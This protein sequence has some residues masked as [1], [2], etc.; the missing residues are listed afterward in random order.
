MNTLKI[1]TRGMQTSF[2]PGAMIEGTVSWEL[3]RRPVSM[4]LRLF[5]HT[6]GVG[7]AEVGVEREIG[8]DEPRRIEQREFQFKLPPGPYSVSGKL[9]TLDWALELLSDNPDQV[10]RYNLTVSPSGRK[11][12]LGGDE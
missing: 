11:V 3:D 2:A 4:R 5:W 10:E 12:L 6:G 8:F 1:E 7:D 9:V